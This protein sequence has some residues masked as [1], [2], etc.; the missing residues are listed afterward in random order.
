[1]NW[2]NIL[3]IA[4]KDLMEVRQNQGAW[5]PMLVVP[6]IFIV[7][8]PLAFL[9]LPAQLHLSDESLG[10][11]AQLKVLMQNMPQAMT[12]SFAGMSTYQSMVLLVLGYMF[13]PMFLIFPL[14]FST[15]IAS[16]SFAGERE[17]KT[18]EALLYSPASD[19][20]LFLGKVLAAGVP[21]VGI[22]WIS[23]FFYTLVTNVAGYQ[24]FGGIWFP[25]P[26]WWALIFWVTP[27]IAL[28]GITFTVLISIKV[29][30]F[31]AAYQTSASTVVLVLPLVG[32]QLSGVLYL[33]VGV[34]ML[35]GLFLWAVDAVLA[36]FAI[37]S[38]NRSRL[39]VNLA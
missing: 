14:M 2:T 22:T 17:R 4:K 26:T 13:A 34:G 25:L 8:F 30:T 3:A 10:S 24:L 18:L 39:L 5:I 31:M 9:I 21:A 16:E 38:F 12:Q 28:F 23:F 36:Y 11:T 15:I 19:A 27:A 29:Q 33:S 37:R 6:L 35:I 7:V 1:M 20:D 32:G